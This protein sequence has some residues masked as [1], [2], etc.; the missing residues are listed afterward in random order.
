[1]K[2]LYILLILLS[3][4]TFYAQFNYQKT[5]GTYYFGNRMV[6][7]NAVID[8]QNNIII[9]GNVNLLEQPSY[10][11]VFT[12]VNAY[13][14]G[15]SGGISDGFIAKFD[16]QGN[17][18]WATYYG[19]T[20]KDECHEVAL[21]SQDNIYIAGFTDSAS[22]IATGGSF[23]PSLP[24]SNA[25]FLTKFSPAGAIQWGTYFPTN[26]HAL[27]INL[28]DEIYIA[29]LTNITTG[30]STSG[31]FQETAICCS[32]SGLP[33][34]D[35]N[36][37]INKFDS[38]GNR[39]SGTYTGKVDGVNGAGIGVKITTDSANNVYVVG[40]LQINSA[41]AGSYGSPGCHQPM[42]G[43]NNNS[44]LSKFNSTLDQRLWST[45]YGG[46][47]AV[48]IQTIETSGSDVYIAGACTSPDNVATPGSHQPSIS[49]SYDGFLVKFNGV[50]V[51]QWGTYYGG[52][53]S[54][55]GIYDVKIKDGYIYVAGGSRSATNTATVGTYQD[56]FLGGP[57]DGFFAQ[58]TIDGV[59]NW[60]SYFGGTGNDGMSSILPYGADS[61]YLVGGTTS[62][63]GIAT[64]DGFQPQLNTGNPPNNTIPVNIYLAKFDH[65]PLGV[66]Q[67]NK[68]GLGLYPNPNNGKFTVTIDKQK[69]NEIFINVFDVIGK[70]VY[71]GRTTDS[72]T[73][74]N[75]PNLK[76]GVYFVT[77]TGE[78]FN[79]SLKFIKN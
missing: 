51:R 33:Y 1:M 17:L 8:T 42:I 14:T 73:E 35:W 56:T 50:G 32:A 61:F 79:E 3:Y 48:L 37:Y 55:P 74:L 64:S 57:G 23:M 31:A 10:Y 58:F 5:W 34:V 18:L 28:N 39:V 45:Y 13:Q 67:Y 29:G 9:T 75:I 72:E 78:N 7:A 36:G 24:N 40:L 46:S 63:T 25:G 26:V 47:N 70:S 44:Y 38:L 11:S 43:G 4:S 12:S 54:E 6:V 19:G 53:G 77:V 68:N 20:G 66:S 21:D 2:K 59:R 41:A 76:T 27:Q 62:S 52:T 22:G 71:S 69:S 60:G 49:G 16:P 65:L 15:V 30:I